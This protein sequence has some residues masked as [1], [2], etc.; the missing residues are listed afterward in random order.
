MFFHVKHMEAIFNF[1]E[2]EH[3]EDSWLNHFCPMEYPHCERPNFQLTLFMADF[4][5]FPN[6][7]I[8]EGIEAESQVKGSQ[9]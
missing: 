6:D 2:V 5:D 3:T 9:M 8:M 4:C 7:T 1:L